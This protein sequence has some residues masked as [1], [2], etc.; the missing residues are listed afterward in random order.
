VSFIFLENTLSIVF[1]SSKE[2][3]LFFTWDTDAFL[4]I[5]QYI[6]VAET[7]RRNNTQIKKLKFIQVIKKRSRNEDSKCIQKF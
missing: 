3:Y 2:K 6:T 5:S 7:V 1:I 4:V